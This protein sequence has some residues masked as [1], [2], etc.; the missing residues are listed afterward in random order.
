MYKNRPYFENS[1]PNWRKFGIS[2]DKHHILLVIDLILDKPG[3]RLF[4]RDFS[5]LPMPL[6]SSVKNQSKLSKSLLVGGQRLDRATFCLEPFD[7]ND[8]NLKRTKY[9][10][11]SAGQSTFLQ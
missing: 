9:L 4:N 3:K 10:I 7:F 5:F 1:G 11:A 6:V 2:V 8:F